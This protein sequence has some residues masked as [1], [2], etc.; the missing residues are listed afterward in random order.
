MN[1]KNLRPPLEPF[2]IKT[3]ER[4][5]PTSRRERENILKEAGFNVFNI[6]AEK[7]LID[8]LTDS[9]TSAMSDQQWAG[10][11]VGDESYA[12]ARSFYHFEAAV[13][14]IFCFKHVIPAHQGRAAERILFGAMVK[15][16]DFVPSNNHFDTTRANI[17][18]REASA[19]DL[20]IDEAYDP[21]SDFPFKGDLDT[22]KLKKFIEKK[23]TKKIP[24]AMLTI[25]N[26]SG[27]GQPVSLKN[28]KE[29]SQICKQHKIPLF[30]D[31]CRF[32]ENAYFIKKR[33]KGYENKSILEI[34]QEIF[35][36]G[37]GATM[38]AKKDALVNIGGFVT[39]DDDQLAEKIKNLLILGEGFPTYGGLAGRDLEAIARGLE[40]V[41]E[42]DYLDYRVGQVAYLGQLLDQAGVPVLKPFGG[43]A[44][45]LL[46]DRF[47]SHIPRHQYPGWALTVALYRQAGIRTS[48]IG[49]V[50]FAKKDPKT[51]GEIYPRLELVR[52]AIPRR[53]YTS[54]QIEYVADSIIKL[55]EKRE[56]VRGMRIVRESPQL[57]HFTIRM[58][59]V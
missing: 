42:E 15:K 41:L 48:E 19:V 35:S 44:I 27:G 56:E 36:Y 54:A 33:E 45:Y 23:G 18:A 40:E 59:E 17:E 49:A 52:L 28:I 5:K 58:E 20:V 14:N 11:M 8:L 50:M 55:Y 22:I 2:R 46:A 57:R 26:N 51:G 39:L 43:H 25:T 21:D 6:P 32:A 3:V 10:L 30:F 7:V 12:G 29:V 47:L 34:A 24:L 53:V 4:I 37:Q 13:K 16:G 1:I 9:G 31:A 38:S